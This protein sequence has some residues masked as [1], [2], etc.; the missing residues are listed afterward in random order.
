M[1]VEPEHLGCVVSPNTHDQ[2]HTIGHCYAHLCRQFL[3]LV[4]NLDWDLK[5]I[6]IVAALLNGESEEEFSKFGDGKLY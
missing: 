3:A 1:R 4:A 2:D 6:D 5:Q